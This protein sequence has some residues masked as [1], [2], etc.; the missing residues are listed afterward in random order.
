MPKLGVVFPSRLGK[1][2]LVAFPLVF[3]MGWTH[4][5]PYFSAATETAADIANTAL[6]KD[7]PYR[8]HPLED[9]DTIPPDASPTHLPLLTKILPYHPSAAQ[10]SMWTS[11][12][13][14]SLAC[15]KALWSNGDSD[16]P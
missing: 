6:Q 7:T 8:P 11:P 4:W 14:I 16:P 5:P 13:T 1:E 15:A 2:K 12:W 9:T 3:P 10:L